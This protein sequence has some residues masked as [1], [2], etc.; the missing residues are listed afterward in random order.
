MRATIT[1]LIITLLALSTS[2][3]VI[4]ASP[5]RLEIA[6]ANRGTRYELNITAIT[7]DKDVSATLKA[8]GDISE[9]TIL[10]KESISLSRYD[11]KVIPI[12]ITI[13]EGTPNGVYNGL[14]LVAATPSPGR[15]GGTGMGVSSAVYV[16]V[17]VVVSGVEG[18]WFRV[19]RTS[20]SNVLEGNPIKTEITVKNNA[21]KEVNPSITLQAKSR[22]GTKTYAT[23][24]LSRE[25]V[26][27]LQREDIVTYLPSAD[28]RAGIYLMEFSIVVDGENVWESAETFYILPV[29]RTVQAKTVKVE[30]IL[31]N[32]RV[33]NAN[34]TLGDEISLVAQFKNTG[35][36]PLDAKIRMDVISEGEII[37][38]EDLREEY[39]MVEHTKDFELSYKPE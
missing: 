23:S 24:S 37:N 39:I 33:Q 22:D 11:P 2:A 3:S 12:S 6:D 20:V 36:V 21:L 7:A 1:I 26:E 27:G 34:L 28:M 14:I 35:E 8:Y 30:G 19:L 38:S 17:K 15:I 25:T 10:P 5:G 13:P 16:R 29:E 4:G 9:W 32:A 31:E 18:Q